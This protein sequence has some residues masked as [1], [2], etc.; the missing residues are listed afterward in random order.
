M[1][2]R[3]GKLGRLGKLGAAEGAV[4]TEQGSAAAG[5]ITVIGTTTDTAVAQATVIVTSR[6]KAGMSPFRRQG[7]TEG[8]SRYCRQ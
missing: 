5:A 3:V 8:V 1:L 6:V 2:G 4:D 7:L